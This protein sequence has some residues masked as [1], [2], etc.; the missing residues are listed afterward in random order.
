MTARR[1]THLD[2]LKADMVALF[3]LFVIAR[4]SGPAMECLSTARFLKAGTV[5]GVSVIA[6]SLRLRTLGL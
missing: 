2:D 3:T 6:N 4:D 5:N 1:G